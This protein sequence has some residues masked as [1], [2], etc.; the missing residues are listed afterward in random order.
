[1]NNE[2]TGDPKDLAALQSI[3]NA[4]KTLKENKPE[5]R[6]EKARRYQITLTDLEKAWATF[7]ALV[8]ADVAIFME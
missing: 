5:E 2:D 3:A 1:M 8:Y 4:I 6:S 7:Y